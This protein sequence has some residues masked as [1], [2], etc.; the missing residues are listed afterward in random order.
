MGNCR[1]NN[2]NNDY[3][4][5]TPVFWKNFNLILFLKLTI[6]ESFIWCIERAKEPSLI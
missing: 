2:N 3:L 4:Q 1:N 6:K 5:G